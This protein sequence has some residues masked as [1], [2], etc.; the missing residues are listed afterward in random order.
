VAK[1][2]TAQAGALRSGL[3][4]RLRKD[5]RG[6]ILAMTGAALIPMIGF[7]GTGVDM[8]RAYLVKTRLQQACD[9][10]ALA[11]RR[12]MAGTTVTQA[13]KDEAVKFFRFNFPDGTMDTQP[14]VVGESEA[15]NTLT[16]GLDANKQIG[17]TATATMPNV[18]MQVLG[19]DNQ[20]IKVRCKAEEYYVNTDVMLVLDTTGSMNCAIYDSLTCSQATEKADSKMLDLRNAVKDLYVNLRPA[21]IALEAKNLRMRIGW[22]P[23][24]TT[25]NVGK[26]VYGENAAYM[27]NPGSY[28]NSSGTNGTAYNGPTQTAAW[29]NGTGASDYQGCIVER[30][31]VAF[32]STA[33]SIP[34]GAYDLD[35]ATMPTS[36]ATR[37]TPLVLS[38]YKKN[39]L[40]ASDYSAVTDLNLKTCP[41]PANHL[42]SWPSTTAFNT[43][44][45]KITTGA[46]YTYHDVGM[47]WGTRLI[48][49]QGI[50]ASRNPDKYNNVKVRRTI[51]MV[52]DGF[53]N[54]ETDVYGAY[55][56]ERYEGRVYGTGANTAAEYEARH[57]KRFTLMCSVAK[58]T[59]INAD[60]WV[61]AI[62][63]ATAVLPQTLLD[64][65]SNSA[66]VIKASNTTALNNAFKAVSDKVGNL[67]IGS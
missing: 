6:N 61:I 32:A 2:D 62:L 23:Y 63:P 39:N 33:T 22:V 31:T 26:L 60:I 66:Q 15:A 11:G 7:I 34:T 55:G 44:I 57:N 20:Q 41:K 52:T 25:A 21:Q 16:V 8:S 3:L 49:N 12:S 35:I 27:I 50:F 28:R 36:A 58:S 10:G 45:A 14:L 5:Q 18:L 67:R 48:A 46:G 40:G 29:F 43:E 56:V 38:L 30:D 51:V 37:W 53:M 9:A 24:S 17:M 4:A 19:F 54:A 65:A 42:Q 59:P 1:I 47:I 13:D 64:C